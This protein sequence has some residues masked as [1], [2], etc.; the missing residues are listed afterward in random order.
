M[1]LTHDELAT[2][3]A[4]LAVDEGAAA[5]F[6]NINVAQALTERGLAIRTRQ[7]WTI[8]P[9]GKSRLRGAEMLGVERGDDDVVIPFDQP[10][11]PQG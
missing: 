4:L 1:D 8:T 7:G 3:K 5:K 10:T 2:L 9:E 11:D 6:V